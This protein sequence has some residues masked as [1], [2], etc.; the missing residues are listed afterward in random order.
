MNPTDWKLSV[1]S[2]GGKHKCWMC[3][4]HLTF[5]IATVDHLKPKSL[6][7]K[8]KPSNFRLACYPCNQ[9]RGNTPL[10]QHQR[11]MLFAKKASNQHGLYRKRYTSHS[12]PA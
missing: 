1:F 3:A 12:K 7:G 4:K 2:G 6:G 8:D 9:K 5:E 10:T 11:Y